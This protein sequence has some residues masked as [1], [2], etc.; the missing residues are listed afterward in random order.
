MTINKLISLGAAALL[1]VPALAT[2]AQKGDGPAARKAPYAA[3]FTPQADTG[4]AVDTSVYVGRDGKVVNHTVTN[5]PVPDTP[6]TRAAYG[7]PDSRGGAYT[8]PVGN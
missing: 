7:G 3:R 4:V 2:A 1:A 8:A 5:G 6:R